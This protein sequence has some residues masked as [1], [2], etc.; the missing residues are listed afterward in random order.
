MQIANF[1]LQFKSVCIL[2]EIFSVEDNNFELQLGWIRN[3]ATKITFV[4][5]AN[6]KLQF[7]S[8]CTGILVEIFSV[9]D[10]N[11]ELQLGWIRNF[12]TK[13]TFVFRAIVTLSREISAT[14][15]KRLS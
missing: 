9:E 8:V 7:K 11:F 5:R 6:F 3:F 15:H 2:V 1:K 13:I 10:N 4:F 14:C 12:A